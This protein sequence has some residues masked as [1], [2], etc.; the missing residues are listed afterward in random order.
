MK[1]QIR[2][3]GIDDAPFEFG[4]RGSKATVIGAVVRAPSYLEGVLR[5]AVSVDGDDSTDNIQKAIEESRFFEQLRAVMIDG[6]ALAGFNI[7][8][9]EALSSSLRM[10]VIT[11]TRDK[12]DMKSIRAALRK[13]FDDAETRIERLS[14]LPVVELKTAHNPI[15]ISFAGAELDEAREI[16]RTTT[17]R[18][19]IPEPIRMAHIIASGLSRGESRGK[20]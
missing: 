10:P 7:I 1:S 20:A 9:V 2:V 11:V 18:G 16:I 19:V 13:Y 8:D 6:I 15:F 4:K 5:F 3:C 12:P 14:R 17:I